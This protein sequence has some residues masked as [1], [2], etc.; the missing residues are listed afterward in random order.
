MV[1]VDELFHDILGGQ[2]PLLS[3]FGVLDYYLNDNESNGG[4][5]NY[6]FGHEEVEVDIVGYKSSHDLDFVEEY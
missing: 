5:D 2:N 6:I 1:G 4:G 3:Y